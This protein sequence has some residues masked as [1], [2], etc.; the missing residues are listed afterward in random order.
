M[1]LTGLKF[2]GVT[3]IAFKRILPESMCYISS[4]ALH[5]ISLSIL[6]ESHILVGPHF[7]SNF[8]LV[9]HAKFGHVINLTKHYLIAMFNVFNSPMDIFG[10]SRGKS[11]REMPPL[12]PLELFT[13]Q[14]TAKPLMRNK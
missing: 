2:V 11:A 7:S 12:C 8:L 9:L 1:M 6:E 13:N 5:R 4:E 10:G 14:C 3:F